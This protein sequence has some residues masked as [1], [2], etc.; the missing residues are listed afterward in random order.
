MNWEKSMVVGNITTTSIR[1]LQPNCKYVI[2]ISGLS[3]NQSLAPREMLDLYGRRSIIEG[4]LEGSYEIISTHTLKDDFVFELFRANQTQNYSAINDSV[5]LGPTGVLGG[6][7]HYGLEL[8]GDA[9]IENCNVSFSCCDDYD[10]ETSSCKSSNKFICKWTA[11]NLV[12][13]KAVVHNVFVT[14]NTTMTQKQN[15]EHR[16]KYSNFMLPCGPALRL[17]GSNSQLKGSAWY[18][19]QVE[20]REGFDTSFKFRISNPSFRY[21][22]AMFKKLGRY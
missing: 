4:A 3:E 12:H 16:Q 5:T 14:S 15:D 11:K 22:V 8:I 1:P 7:G 10:Y 17:T 20:V 6:E 9:S 2:A 18:P 21:V 19:R 13:G